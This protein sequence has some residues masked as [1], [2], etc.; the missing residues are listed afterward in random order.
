MDLPQIADQADIVIIY[1]TGIEFPHAATGKFH[2]FIAKSRSGLSKAFAF[3]NHA[4]LILHVAAPHTGVVFPQ[5]SGTYGA[6]HPAGRYH[7][8]SFHTLR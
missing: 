1:I 3:E 7:I 6:I 2:A 8:L 5:I 4:T